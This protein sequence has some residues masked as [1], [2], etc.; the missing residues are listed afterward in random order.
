MA[1]TI[2]GSTPTFSAATGYAGGT[3]TSGTVLST[4]SGNS[5]VFTGIPSWA[6]RI[7]IN[8][9]GVSQ[10]GTTQMEVRL[11]TSGGIVSTGYIS[12]AASGLSATASTTST[13][14]FRIRNS[15]ASDDIYGT[16]FLSLQTG[17]TWVCS[18]SMTASN[19]AFFTGGGS[20]ALAS[21]LTQVQ[22][23]PNGADNF[24]AGSVNILYE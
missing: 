22:V 21:A 6:K 19:G 1:V 2:S 8:F 23:T 10:T 9:I 16:M 20:I 24:D 4:S 3:I 17:N 14:G 7:S 18:Y 15:V 12:G 11:G 13:T 5:A